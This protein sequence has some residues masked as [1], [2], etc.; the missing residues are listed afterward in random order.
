[1]ALED[2]QLWEIIRE[3]GI[4]NSPKGFEGLIHVQSSSKWPKTCFQPQ[5]HR[6]SPVACPERRHLSVLLIRKNSIAIYKGQTC[7]NSTFLIFLILP[8]AIGICP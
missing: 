1:M 4:S 7:P 8:P 5:Q 6:L 3:V 2:H